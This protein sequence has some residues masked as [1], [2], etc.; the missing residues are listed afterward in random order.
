MVNSFLSKLQAATKPI[1]LYGTG[2]AAEKIIKYLNDNNITIAG[3]FASDGFVR[4]RSFCGYKIISYSDAKAKNQ[5][6]IVLLAFGSHLESVIE[7]I[8]KIACE[9]ELYAPDLAIAGTD[10]F[11]YDEN[12]YNQLRSI[13]AD[14]KSR[15]VL[16]S[17]VNYKISGDIK[18]LLECE[19]DDDENWQ[20]LKLSSDEEYLD[21]GAYTGDTV[22]QF[23]A[24]TNGYYNSIYAVEPETRNYR[25]L[26]ENCSNLDN[27]TL[28]NCAVSSE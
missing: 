24:L 12:Q 18:Y 9:Q 21:L 5:N 16:D 19:T 4:D 26:T 22:R 25:K 3:I 17:V 11:V 20:L 2:N 8:K 28:L 13:L 15:E 14:D 6:M 10:N 1:Y 27:C 23:L 7:N